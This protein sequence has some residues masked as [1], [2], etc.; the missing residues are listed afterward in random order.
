MAL[1]W[2]E[3]TEDCLDLGTAEEILDNDHFGLENVKERILDYLAVRKLTVSAGQ[4][5]AVQILCLAGPPGVG[6]TSLGRSIA[7]AMGRNFVRVSLGGVGMKP[8]FAATVGPTSAQCPAGS[9]AR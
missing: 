6:K 5:D 9:S 8:I 4:A 2:H 1:P 3:R 7:T